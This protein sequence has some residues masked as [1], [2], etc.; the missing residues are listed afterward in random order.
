VT[1][2]LHSRREAVGKSQDLLGR[3]SSA[4]FP[5]FSFKL[6]FQGC[7]DRRSEAFAGKLSEFGR[8]SISARVF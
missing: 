1:P 8:K 3:S 6:V 2:R 4:A 7:D 5:P